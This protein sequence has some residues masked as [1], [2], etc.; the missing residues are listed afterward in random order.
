MDDQT[1]IALLKWCVEQG[2]AFIESLECASD[3][4]DIEQDYKDCLCLIFERGLESVKN[5][6]KSMTC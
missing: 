4:G 5:E 3:A 1:R 6:I 2:N